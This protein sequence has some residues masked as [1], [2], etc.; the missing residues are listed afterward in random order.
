ML[1]R[2][3]NILQPTISF[4][5]I[6][7]SDILVWCGLLLGITGILT[8]EEVYPGYTLFS[9][10][11]SQSAGDG[12]QIYLLGPDEDMVHTWAVE[13]GS[14][15]NPYLLPDSSVYYPYRTPN[16]TMETGG[17]GGGLI[18]LDWDGNVLWEYLISEPN[19]QAH[20]DIEI[21]PNG[22]LLVIAWQRKTAAEAF[23]M[24]RLNIANPLNEMWVD[25]IL[26]LQPIG[27]DDALVVW[28]WHLWDHLIQDQN[29]DLPGYGMISEHPELM[30]INFGGVGGIGPG[31]PHADW[32]HFNC[33]SYHAELDQILITSRLFHEV[34]IIDHSTTSAEAASHSGGNSGKGGDF[35]YRWGNPQTYG[36]GT[37]DDQVLSGPHGGVW[38][39]DDYPGAGNILIFNNGLH[40]GNSEVIELVPPLNNEELYSFIAG[41]PFGPADAVWTYSDTY[42]YSTAL[43]GALRLPNGNTLVTVADDLRI[44]E[45]APSGQ[46]LWDY[47]LLGGIIAIPRAVKYDLD[48]FTA[49][50]ILFGDINNDSLLD[51]LDIV[52]IVGIILQLDPWPPAAD[53]NQDDLVDILDVILLVDLILFN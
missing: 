48:Y 13:Y 4:N 11:P 53:I 19:L 27:S 24:G 25:M 20:H 10:L 26:E 8:A 38:I 31:G 28:E 16:P 3:W 21:L 45:I 30:N 12:T 18:R 32:T 50:N 22:N 39:N 1:Y 6:Q 51:I 17:T 44:F 15:M 5:V 49:D 47:S 29:P 35:L 42:F 2:G 7:R 36:L 33:V 9:P 37:A 52:A 34:F 23:A 40:W 14:S 46:T 43:S 41:S